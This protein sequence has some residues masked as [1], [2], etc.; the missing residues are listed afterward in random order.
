MGPTIG[1]L[2]ERAHAE[3]RAAVSTLLRLLSL[4]HD[5]PRRDRRLAG[6]GAPPHD[7]HATCAQAHKLHRLALPLRLC[8]T[9]QRAHQP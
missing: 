5:G 3:A 8:C 2:Y 4:R 1:V 6:D 7:T 9:L